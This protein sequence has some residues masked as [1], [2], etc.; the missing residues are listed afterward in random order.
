MLLKGIVSDSNNIFYDIYQKILT[1][2]G[3]FPNFTWFQ[4][5]IYQLCMIVCIGIAK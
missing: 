5:Y 1:K 3:Y 4:F 2:M